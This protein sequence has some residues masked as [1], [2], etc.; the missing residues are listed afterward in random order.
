MSTSPSTAETEETPL[1][2]NHLV[3]STSPYLLQHAHNPVDWFPWGDEALAKAKREGKP[4]FLSIGYSAC[5]WCHVM[6]RESFEDEAV[7][8]VLNLRFVP[9]KVDREERPDIDRI[10]MKAVQALTGS[11]GWPLSV[12]LTPSLQPFYGGTYFPPTARFGRPAFRELLV[13]IADAWEARPDEVTASAAAITRALKSAIP[14]ADTGGQPGVDATVAAAVDHLRGAFDSRWGGF[15]SAPKF[16]PSGSLRLLMRRYVAT[17]DERLLR[18]VHTTLEAMA[19]GG[20]YDHLGGGFHRYSVDDQWLVPHFEK[21]LYDN[22]LLTLVYLEAYQLTRRE[23]YGRVAAETLL[24]VQREMTAESGGFF[25][26]QDADSEGVE[27]KFYVW[28][29][30]EIEAVLGS[31]D[32]AVF[33]TVYGVT[34]RGN[35]EGENILHLP[36]PIGEAAGALGLESGELTRTLAGMRQRLLTRRSRRAPPPTDDKILTAWNGLM[37]SAF[38]RGYQVLGDETYLATAEKAARFILSSLMSDGL[39]LRTH[40]LGKSRLAAYLDDYA[41]MANALVDLYESSFRLE[42]LT[43]A[44]TLTEAMIA[45]FWDDE[46]HGLFFTSLR[47][48]D[49]LTREKSYFDESRPSGN[50]VAAQLLLRLAQLTG[51]P[52]YRD[53]AEQ[54][55]EAALLAAGRVPQAMMHLLCAAD[56]TRTQSTEIAI[57]GGRGSPE[58]AGLLATVRSVFLPGTIVTFLDPA[59][60]GASATSEKVP[61][62]AGKSM[63]GGK[64]TAYVCVDYACKQPVTSTESLLAALESVRGSKRLGTVPQE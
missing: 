14:G 38:A 6:E 20:M 39:L 55:I 13:R 52:V 41:F 8:A 3:D 16:P 54:L 49:L 9:I 33:N 40:R 11:G 23:L 18:M 42:W 62:L 57:V 53:R 50:A 26:S 5:H 45:E 7:A 28:S 1:H 59:E 17:G 61:V 29:R 4:I 19:H 21:M 22:A 10:Y 25:S 15:G 58:A 51:K 12:F 64:A 36:K 56:L 24:Y 31:D 48:T 34:R 43:A 44:E 30:H 60:G 32:A 47:H 35:F 46:G 27:G 2:T 63:V 37:L